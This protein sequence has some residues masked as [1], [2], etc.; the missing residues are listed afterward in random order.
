MRDR[1]RTKDEG[2]RTRGRRMTKA[3]LRHS[4]FVL[5]QAPSMRSGGGEFGHK[6]V[7]RFWQYEPSI[8]VS[9]TSRYSH[10]CIGACL[11]VVWVYPAVRVVGYGAC[12]D[13]VSLSLYAHGAAGV[14]GVYAEVYPADKS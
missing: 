14:E 3:P 12:S 13:G 10:S 11:D 5:R 4:S 8:E 2:R 6:L 7:R 9:Q 1:R